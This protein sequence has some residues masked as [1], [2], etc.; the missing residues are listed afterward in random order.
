[1]I[2]TYQ[3]MAVKLLALNI[4]ILVPVKCLM[5]SIFI[6]TLVKLFALGILNLTPVKLLAVNISAYS[7]LAQGE[8]APAKVLALNYD[9][10]WVTW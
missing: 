8:S 9:F 10:N 5:I 2:C 7:I 6:L 1:M 3:I 4:L